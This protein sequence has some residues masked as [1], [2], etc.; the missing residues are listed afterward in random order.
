[1]NY[2]LEIISRDAASP[3]PS[4]GARIL[5][6]ASSRLQMNEKNETSFVGHCI[7]IGEFV[8]LDH[9]TDALMPPP[10]RADCELI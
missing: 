5:L 1:M 7:C 3:T 8:R 10:P 6:V 9:V 4:R 2:G